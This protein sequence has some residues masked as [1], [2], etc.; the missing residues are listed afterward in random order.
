M[1]TKGEGRQDRKGHTTEEWQV[2]RGDC[3]LYRLTLHLFQ[4]LK[5]MKVNVTFTGAECLF[6]N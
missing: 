5:Y 1:E 4:K 6:G 3:C 2:E